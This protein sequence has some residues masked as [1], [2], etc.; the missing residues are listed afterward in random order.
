[1]KRHK[2]RLGMLMV[3]A[4]ASLLVACAVE[5]DELTPDETTTTEEASSVPGEEPAIGT[6]ALTANSAVEGVEV[7][8]PPCRRVT[9]SSIPVYTTGTGSTVRCRFLRGD[10]FSYVASGGGRYLTWCPRRTP[11]GQGVFSWA[12][13]AGTVAVTC[14]W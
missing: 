7:G 2:T 8:G 1:M 5:G 12:Q 13:G 6:I 14:P 10:V 11:P 4:V 3:T 9:A